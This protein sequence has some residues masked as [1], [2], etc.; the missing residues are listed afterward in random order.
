MLIDCDTCTVR[1]K[2]CAG[3]LVTALFE[4]PPGVADIGAAEQYAIEVLARAGLEVTVLGSE[5]TPR[6]M[7]RQ[8]DAQVGLRYRA[9][10]R[11]KGWEGAA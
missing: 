1:G 7:L 8:A 9:G 2:A 4:A 11:K 3:C 6:H 10:S 5:P